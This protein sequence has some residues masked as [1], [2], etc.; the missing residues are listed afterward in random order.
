M[1]EIGTSLR[2]ARLRRELDFSTLEAITKVRAKYLRALED[3]RFELLPSHTYIKGFLRTYA[4]SLGLDGQ[5]YVD[6]YSSR[7]VAGLDDDA[8]VRR[9]RPVPAA[10]RRRQ[11][12]RESN[13]VLLALT[14]IALVTALVIAAW[15]FGGPEPANVNGLRPHV[16]PSATTAKPP[17]SSAKPATPA[18]KKIVLVVRAAAGDS[19]MEVRAAAPSGR[20]LYGGT[21]ERGQTQR[22]A[23]TALYVSFGAPE[24]VTLKVNGKAVNVPRGGAFRLS[25]AGLVPVGPA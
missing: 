6:E 14:A 3:E 20:L 7:Y 8:R 19:W 24:N 11:E 21:L 13:V 4:D 22:F 2:E 9:R 1:F 18:A 17:G 10:R 15:K 23:S 5:L 12:R 25:R 16:S